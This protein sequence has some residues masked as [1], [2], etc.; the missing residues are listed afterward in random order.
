[1]S[2]PCKFDLR[3]LGHLGEALGK[4]RLRPERTGMKYAK[5]RIFKASKL[6]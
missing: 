1:M 2:V 6:M 3:G 4:I 5:R